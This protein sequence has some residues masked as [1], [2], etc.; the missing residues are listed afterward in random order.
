MAHVDVSQFYNLV[1]LAGIIPA[2]RGFLF[3]RTF[4]GRG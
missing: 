1:A 2:W 3:L 4:L